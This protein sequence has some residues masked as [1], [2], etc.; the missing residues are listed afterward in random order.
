MPSKKLTRKRK[1]S[2]PLSFAEFSKRLDEVDERAK[3]KEQRSKSEE[4]PSGEYD[5]SEIFKKPHGTPDNSPQKA[6][7]RDTHPSEYVS[8]DK[9]MTGPPQFLSKPTNRRLFPGG[10][11]RSRKSRKSHKKRK[12][13]Y[14]KT[15][16]SRR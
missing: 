14:K 3:E 11:R 9:Y 2:V 12:S 16:R 5:F 1:D 15:K 8:Y 4:F 6:R 13:H 7:R 10:R